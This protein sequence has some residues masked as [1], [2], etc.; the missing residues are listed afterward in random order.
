MG[1]GFIPV[2]PDFINLLKKQVKAIYANPFFSSL[3]LLPFDN[4][5]PARGRA[6]DS[7]FEG[8]I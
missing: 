8:P 6:V 5:Q 7:K 2:C 1:W 3:R 4:R